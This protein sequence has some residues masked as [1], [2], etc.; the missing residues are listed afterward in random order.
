MPTLRSGLPWAPRSS[1]TRDSA[2]PRAG[3]TTRSRC[4]HRSPESPRVSG[5]PPA[6]SRSGAARR[7]R[8]R[9]PRRAFNGRPTAASPSASARAA[10][11]LSRACTDS[12]GNGRSVGC[13]RRSSPSERCSTAPACRSTE[14]TSG[15]FGWARR[16]SSP[17]R[18]CSR[19]SPRPRSGWR[20]SWRTSGCRSS[21]PARD[22]PTA[23]PC[24][25]R[26]RRL[27]RSRRRPG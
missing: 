8:S 25:P 21:G 24:S 15:R 6:C 17:S 11:R 10:R 20:V 19:H 4:S 9:W 5:L 2:L 16:P 27:P 3:P 18:S 7:R 1:A 22:S 14:R 13:G 26:A 12:P 23:E